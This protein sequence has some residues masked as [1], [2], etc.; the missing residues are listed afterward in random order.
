MALIVED[1]TGKPDSNSYNDVTEI[2]AF[3]D[4]RGY[5]LPEDDVD[6][7]KLAI[8]AT[9]YLESFRK[10]YQGKK[11][12]PTVQALSFPRTGVVIDDE[13]LGD[14]AIPREL[15]ASHAQ[16]TVEA[17]TTDLLANSSAFVKKE[18]VDVIEV[19]YAE[20]STG[21]STGFTKVDLLLEPLLG[22]S[23]GFFL[24]SLRV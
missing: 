1:G 7:E 15:K 20:S 4:A 14:E 5:E 16:A 18:K 2:R 22:T 19:E 10:L 24:T 12:Y 6:V 11:T 17:Y 13:P 3:A 21:S 9:D 8:Q 23:G